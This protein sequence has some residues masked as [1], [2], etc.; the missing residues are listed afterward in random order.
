[1]TMHQSGQAASAG[2]PGLLADA[3]ADLTDDPDAPLPCVPTAGDL[4]LV[5]CHACSKL[6]P[7]QREGSTCLRCG[8]ALS[9]RKPASLS[10]T[11]A[12]LVAA[13]I[14]YIPANTL[15][16]MLTSSLRDSQQDTI[17]SGIIYLWLTGA[18]MLALIVLVA[19]IIV[20]LMKILILTYLLLSVHWR[21]TRGIRQRT[22]LYRMIEVIG[23]WSMLDIFVVAL[24][25]ALV[26]DGIL[27]TVLPGPGAMA[28]G[29]VVVM[30]MLASLSFDPR[31]MWDVLEKKDG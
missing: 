10:R 9:R 1:M 22:R 5:S 16:I 8:G 15:P 13:C 3:L 18:R 25:A 14:L 30:T 21:S 2:T 20:P 31:L 23:R 12:F 26:R 24:L 6:S 11:W 19:S 4:D 29:A 27:A 28:F 7:R 17:L